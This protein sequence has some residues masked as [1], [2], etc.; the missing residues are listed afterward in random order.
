MSSLDCKEIRSEVTIKW[1][2]EF[3]AKFYCGYCGYEFD[4]LPR[5]PDRCPKCRKRLTKIC[6]P[7]FEPRQRI[8]L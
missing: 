2:V 1:L 7:I 3:G 8:R 5:L 4:V 6:M